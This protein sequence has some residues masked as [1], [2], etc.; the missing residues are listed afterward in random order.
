MAHKPVKAGIIG[1]GSISDAY[2]TMCKKFKILDLASCADIVMERAEAKAQQHGLTA[3]TVDQMLADDDLEIV[4]NLTIPKVHAEVNLAAID[5]GKNVHVEKPFA[6]TRDE[7]RKVLDAAKAKGVLTGAAPDTFLGA[8]LQ[9][10]RK[11]IDEGAIGRPIAATA[12]MAC[13]GH[14]SW[15]PDP[16]FYYAPGGG[17]MFDMGPYYITALVSLMGPVKRVTGSTGKAFD[18]RT[19][20]SE[21]KNGKVIPVEVPTHVAGVMDFDNGAIATIVT[22]FDVWTHR[23]PIIEIYGAEGTMW[24]PDPNGFGGPVRI[25]KDWDKQD[26]IAL[27]HTADPNGRGMGPADMAYAL[28]TGRAHRASGE[29][30]NHVLDIMWAFHDASDAGKHIELT[31]TCPQPAPLPTGLTPGELD[32]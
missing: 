16:E 21:K 17:P 19:I 5:A 28:R 11:L 8:G 20:T 22:S 30:G 26:E 1:C 12:F 9:T 23:L 32:D 3:C 18:E 27:T 15:H 7:A 13:H 14:E 29:L 6:V 10:C 2:F 4:I 25:G 31:T 24:A